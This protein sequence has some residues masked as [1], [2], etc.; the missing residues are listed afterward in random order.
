MGHEKGGKQFGF[1]TMTYP[2]DCTYSGSF[3]DS[4]PHGLGKIVYHEDSKSPLKEYYG[5]V[6]GKTPHGF[7][8]GVY[9]D[10]QKKEYHVNW[11]D[12]NKFEKKDDENNP[13]L[14]DIIKEKI[15]EDAAKFVKMVPTFAEANSNEKAKAGEKYS[16]NLRGTKEADEKV[17]AD[18]AY[19][20][21]IAGATPKDYDATNVTKIN[22]DNGANYVGH[23]KD[24]KQ[25]YGY[26]TMTYPNDC[27]YSGSFIN[28]E[29]EGL[30]KIVY[31]ED[32]KSPLKEYYGFVKGPSPHGF[33]LGVYKDGQK[34]VYHVKW[35]DMNTFKEDDDKNNPELLYIIKKKIQE[36]AAKFVKEVPVFKEKQWGMKEY[37]L[38]SAAVGLGAAGLYYAFSKSNG[39]S[40]R[41][42]KRRS[43]SRSKRRSRSRS[44]RRSQSK[45]KS[46][47]S[48]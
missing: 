19:N 36:D 3:I 16:S 10:G 31:H 43:K 40:K 41:R 12:M 37:G 25:P 34:P 18:K 9:K 5:F 6:N 44:K 13:E 17:K 48:Q 33:G 11:V 14:L 23:A 20:D 24:D 4:K 35:V 39:K 28:N 46:K 2:N 21:A 8:L 42:S 7:G 38:A 27:T 47:R 32:S 22:L 26:G 29:F 15:Q 45:S 30:G 1:G